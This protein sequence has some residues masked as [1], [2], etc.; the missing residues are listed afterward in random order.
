MTAVNAQSQMDSLYQNEEFLHNG[1]TLRYRIMYPVNYDEHKKYP[2]VLFLHGKGER[3]IDNKKQLVHGGSLFADSTIRK[4]FPAIV[5]FPQCAPEDYWC[6]MNMIED[7]T[8]TTPEKVE[9]L[10][11]VPPGK[12]L[13]LVMQL[14]DSLSERKQVDQRRMYVMGLSMGGRGTFELLWRKP[15]FF[16]AAAPVCGGGNPSSAAIYGKKFPIW[17]FHGA[18]DN[19]VNVNDSRNM[20]TAL[21]A[22]GAKV[23]YTEYPD[24][25]HHVWDYALADP[26]LLPW[27]FAQRKKSGNKII[28]RR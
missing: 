16:S 18:M 17:I 3:G 25:G 5:I 8:D 26:N 2:V 27:L 12:S 15:H 23:K 20:V 19:V 13:Q 1:D 9:Y 11:D 21:Q 24:A 28:G 6:R 4:K 10:S 22:A 14:M 7:R